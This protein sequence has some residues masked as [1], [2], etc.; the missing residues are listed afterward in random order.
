MAHRLA[1]E[2]PIADKRGRRDQRMLAL[3][4]I[5]FA[6]VLVIELV[7]LLARR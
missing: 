7:V 6:L 3:T 1:R 4:A 2:A 5:L